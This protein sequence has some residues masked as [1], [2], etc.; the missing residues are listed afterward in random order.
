MRN[1]STPATRRF[2]RD[3][4]PA[5]R[6]HQR[7]A[8]AAIVREL[9]NPDPDAVASGPY[10]GRRATAVMA[11]G[12]GKTWVAAG[13]AA[14]L[15]GHDRVLVLVPTLDLL[16]QT[17]TAWQRAG[18]VGG[19]Q[20][21][22][23]SPTGDRALAEAGVRTTTSAPR[24]ALWADRDGPLTVYATYQSLDTILT[25]HQGL[26]GLRLAPWRLVCIDEGH[27]TSG[28]LGKRWAAVHD[29]R[30]LPAQA[31][32]YLTATPR[33]WEPPGN[34][35]YSEGTG[36]GA[37]AQPSVL[38]DEQAWEDAAPESPR[39]GDVDIEDRVGH[40][41]DDDRPPVRVRGGRPVH[42]A[43]PVHAVASMDDERIFGSTVHRL[44]LAAGCRLGLLAKP[45]I[46]VV[47]VA[48]PHVHDLAAEAGVD[49]NR[50]PGRRSPREIE[51][52]RAAR[53][54]ALQTAVLRVAAEQDL[55]TVIAY[56]ARTVEA[57]ACAQTLPAV[58]ARLHERDPERFP[59]AV[60][61]DWL[62]G[63]H[64][65]GHRRRV[66][67][68]FAAHTDRVERAGL[69]ELADA[70]RKT[71]TR[72]AVLSNVRVLAEGVDLRADAVAFM[73]PK[74]SVIEIVQAIG[75]VLRQ[76]PHEGRL[77]TIIVPVFLA[78]GEQPDDMLVSD[79]YHFLVRVLHALAAHDS[80]V[81]DML[82]TPAPS[83]SAV[84]LSP[85]GAGP[86]RD[87]DTGDAESEPA[88]GHAASAD[89][90]DRDDGEYVGEDERAADRDAEERFLVRFMTERDPALLADFVNLRVIDP[91]RRD[92]RR[93]YL[94]A[95]RR[96]AVQ[97]DLRVPL[98][99][100]DYDPE[101]GTGY[102][103]GQWISEQRRA[104]AV[105]AITLRRIKL[106]EALGMVWNTDDTAF[107]DGLAMCRAYFAVHGHLAAPKTA[108]VNNYPVGQFLANCRRPLSSRK[109]PVRWAERW[110]RIAAID[111]DWNP[112]G[113]PDPAQRWSLEW[114]RM[115]ALVRLHLEAGG[116]PDDLVPGHTIG[117]E[118]VGAW[119]HRQLRGAGTPTEAQR[120]ALRSVGVPVPAERSGER[121]QP[122]RPVDRWRLTLT[123]ARAFRA[124]EGHLRVPR[125][126]VETIEMDGAAHPVRLGVALA[127]ARRRRAGWPADR[128]E[129]LSALDMR[130]T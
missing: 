37:D 39:A 54:A 128:I 119:L 98:E 130:W 102:P 45:R 125:G 30:R 71:T 100:I 36:E 26:Y 127:N 84:R 103:I 41:E 109:N 18:R 78:A 111:P 35:A 113:R 56:H 68:D 89:T 117:G 115:L 105:G 114:Q 32:L 99:A 12:T 65:V 51:E 7:D 81:L 6:P 48:D 19:N 90:G 8:L 97:G 94:A 77:A 82:A 86:A 61:A 92:W 75:R 44:E 50:G 80:R 57:E 55:A 24:L 15:A 21:A 118:D 4:A 14:T 69:F 72:R 31:R 11:C 106:L 129:A 120:R 64:E 116:K 76:E 104:W 23:C 123:A 85:P 34:S 40:G 25:A 22:V 83:G 16:V 42:S 121:P 112:A 2:A 93:G 47:D 66:L 59:A 87:D 3:S 70:D 52:Y 17:V 79:S 124:R 74:L 27:R 13:A 49:L 5:L 110:D 28:W 29:D 62:C 46:V 95:R 38:V 60:W 126:H 108:A 1:R 58:A 96:H 53:L 33:V 91:E 122:A 63:E 20:L 101:T 67:A 107:E 9:E 43:L 10:S 88:S 73:D